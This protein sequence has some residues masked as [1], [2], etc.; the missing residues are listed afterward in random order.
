MSSPASTLVYR[1]QMYITLDVNGNPS[2]F[3][4]IHFPVLLSRVQIKL[5]QKKPINE[6][7]TF[8]YNRDPNTN[9]LHD[10]DITSNTKLPSDA[11]LTKMILGQYTEQQRGRSPFD[12]TPISVGGNWLAGGIASHGLTTR[13]TYVVP[14]G[15]ICI[16]TAVH[17]AV[18]CDLGGAAG[19]Y[20]EG[21]LSYFS[22]QG[23][24]FNSIPAAVVT[25]LD[26]APVTL[27][28]RVVGNINVT[29]VVYAFGGDQLY[30]KSV[31]SVGGATTA[32]FTL[33]WTGTEFSL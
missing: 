13:T 9:N 4:I 25:T 22:A 24:A 1:A 23:G 2:Q 33:T 15:R 30:L 3:Q 5:A 26:A 17:L 10:V 21:R 29:P 27:D 7:I 28:P 12:R 18:Y 8:K 16:V 11:E 14:A 6:I 32:N 19:W 20:A 31:L